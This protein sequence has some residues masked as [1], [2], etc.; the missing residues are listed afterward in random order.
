L[1][2]YDLRVVNFN[3][4]KNLKEIKKSTFKSTDIYR[5]DIPQSVEAIGESA[6]SGCSYLRE[7][8]F[9]SDSKLTSISSSA[10]Y[11]C[12]SLFNIVLPDGMDVVPHSALKGTNLMNV[13]IPS[14]VTAIAA[15]NFDKIVCICSDSEDSYAKEYAE[16]KGIEFKICDGTHEFPKPSIK[17]NSNK[18]SDMYMSGEKLNIT[19][20]IK[21]VPADAKV[22]YSLKNL[23]TGFETGFWY[24][25]LSSLSGSA[26]NMIEIT[27][28][29][30]VNSGYSL[31]YLV[32]DNGEYIEDSIV[33][34][35]NSSFSA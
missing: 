7:I 9:G 19:A 21:N 20:E 29:I 25:D 17:L 4:N 3:G 23:I 35:I 22:E 31:V 33:I 28:R 30:Y 26:P 1:E 16:L 32:D 2:C 11:N 27:G 14:T 6:F 18:P 8:N 12:V 13:H 24:S 34:T 10:F 5:I 15:E